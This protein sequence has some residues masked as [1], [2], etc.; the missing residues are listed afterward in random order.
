MIALVSLL[1]PWSV[2]L[3]W[4][5]RSIVWGVLGPHMKLVDLLMTKSKNK[6][7]QT[8]N[9]ILH[10]Q[11]KLNTQEKKARI[12]REEAVK[13]RAAKRLR[14]GKYI[15]KV[16]GIDLLRHHDRPLP[17][18]TARPWQGTFMAPKSHEI[19]WHPKQKLTGAMILRP[20]NVAESN[21]DESMEEK[22][23]F[24]AYRKRLSLKDST[25]E[26]YLLT[27]KV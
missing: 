20:K 22:K 23:R 1:L 16:P 2:I 17:E 13:L 9:D 7:C 4:T 21:K 25:S 24:E 12:R 19:K 10:T 18:S 8:S 11:E 15:L 26:K 27:T 14:F 6:R 5:G 3:T